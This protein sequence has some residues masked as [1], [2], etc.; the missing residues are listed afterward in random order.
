MDNKNRK[1]LKFPKNFFWGTATSSHQIEGGLLN[2]WTE[3]EKSPER[4]KGLE[5]KGL[6]PNEYIS[7]KASNSFE[8][9]DDDLDCIKKLNSNAYRFSIEWSR[10]EP[11]EGY[12][13]KKAIEYYREVIK[14][15]RKNNIEP[16]VTLYH[17]PIPL[18]FRDMGSWEKRKNIKYFLR[19]SEKIVTEFKDDVK[20][21]VTINEPMVYSSHSYLDGKWPPNKKSPQKFFRVVNNLAKAHRRAYKIIKKINPKAQ[22][23]IAKQN[24][25]FEAHKNRFW[26][27]IP[28]K[29]INWL[30]SEY[31]L[32]KIKKTQDFVGFNYY[33]HFKIKHGLFFK[34]ENLELNDL[35]WE[36]FP[37][38]IYHELVALKK[39]KLP[40]YILENG[41]A[42]ERDTKR[43]KCI[44]EHLEYVH[45]AIKEGA[46]VRGYF[47]WSLID[48]FEWAEGFGSK[49][50]LFEVDRENDFERK[51]RPSAEY[52]AKICKSNELEV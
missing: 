23:G 17:W 26:N 19:Y 4:V 10:I 20:F 9:F 13:D 8:M 11:R 14:E 50:G 31:F 52:Y 5:K 48:N 41:L 32:N 46:D 29:I 21:W 6:S 47:H 24:I 33:K 12:F 51:M 30:W 28:A 45:Q 7:S 38:G 49:F 22:V 43:K 34:N 37:E 2:D 18:W 1:K 35:G 44:K 3:W 36:I 39:F 15:L 16:F 25:Y 42:D 27:I 40:I